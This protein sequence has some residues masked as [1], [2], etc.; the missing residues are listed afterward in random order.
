MALKRQEAEA[1]LFRLVDIIA[2]IEGR[3][4]KPKPK[5]DL[6][7]HISGYSLYSKLFD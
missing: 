1:L 5:Y 7:D 2:L 4:A 3:K 6:V